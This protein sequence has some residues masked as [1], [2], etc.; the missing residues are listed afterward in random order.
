MG[1]KKRRDK[2]ERVEVEK[3]PDGIA[4]FI[5]PLGLGL[6]EKEEEQEKER[7]LRDPADIL[8]RYKIHR[9]SPLA[10]SAR[11]A[12]EPGGKLS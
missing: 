1:G 11:T 10:I 5:I 7:S 8:G 2:D 4:Q 6:N 3:E 12:Q 9:T